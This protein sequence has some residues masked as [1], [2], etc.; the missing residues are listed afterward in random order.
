MQSVRAEI[1]PKNPVRFMVPE[2]SRSQSAIISYKVRS[3]AGRNSAKFRSET[4]QNLFFRIIFA[5]ESH[6]STK[7]VRIDDTRTI[8]IE[9]VESLS[10]MLNLDKV[11]R[12]SS[13]VQETLAHLLV[14]QVLWNTKRR[15]FFVILL[16]W[17][18]CKRV[19]LEQ[20]CWCLLQIW[21]HRFQ[22]GCSC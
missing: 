9:Q 5:Q 16:I 19:Q 1:I 3:D 11:V 15:Y 13:C 14:G 17:I 18:F 20:A 12:K 22:I 2:P 7:L 21:R 6:T 4:N 8:S 10:E